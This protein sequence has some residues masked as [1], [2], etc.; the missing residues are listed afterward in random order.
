MSFDR[1]ARFYDQLEWFLAGERLQQCRVRWV[2]ELAGARRVLLLGEGHGRFLAA[3]RKAN[4]T[5]EIVC[6]DAS[7]R[8]LE[9]ARERLAE[10]GQFEGITR[11]IH[12]DAL[13]L[14]VCGQ[15]DAIATQ[16]FLDCFPR[17]ELEGLI[18]DLHARLNPAGR[19]L[20]CD[21]QI[22]ERGWRRWRATAVLWL[23]YR[24]F[25]RT[26][27]LSAKR[28]HCPGEFLIRSG[29]VR[30]AREEFNHGLIYAEIWRAV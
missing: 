21:F 23:A 9:R 27:K 22:P 25:R 19:W 26:A 2:H 29:L 12:G 6:V 16:F 13:H 11:F 1:L 17:R 8:M 7:Q 4:P 20:I 14:P 3:L 5:A 15:F 18:M 24:F 10:A 30:E 28:L